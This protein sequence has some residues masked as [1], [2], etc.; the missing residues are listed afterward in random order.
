MEVE[1]RLGVLRA[2]VVRRR[3]RRRAGSSSSSSA[4]LQ[5]CGCEQ[6]A[7]DTLSL[8]LEL[9]LRQPSAPSGQD[10]APLHRLSS[11]PPQP[12]YERRLLATLDLSQWQ[13]SSGEGEGVVLDDVASAIADEE[14]LVLCCVAAACCGPSS[15]VLVYHLPPASS[16]WLSPQ[17]QTTD[18]ASPPS[19]TLLRAFRCPSPRPLHV[20]HWLPLSHLTLQ[21]TLNLAQQGFFPSLLPTA[22]P[23][24]PRPL[25]PTAPHDSSGGSAEE[26]GLVSTL[27]LYSRCTLY[28]LRTFR[29]SSSS[30]GAPPDHGPVL[31]PP[32]LPWPA[33]GAVLE[34]VEA[35]ARQG[36]LPEAI[37]LCR[38]LLQ[39]VPAD[40]ASASSSSSPWLPPAM[41]TDIAAADSQLQEL[42]GR[43]QLAKRC[44]QWMIEQGE[45]GA[46]LSFL[47]SNRDYDLHD[48]VGVLLQAGRLSEALRGSWARGGAQ[49][50]MATIDRLALQ[51]DLPLSHDDMAWLAQRQAPALLS[52]AQGALAA[53]LPPDMRLAMIF[54]DQ[55]LLLQQPSS[56]QYE[57]L[58]TSLPWLPPAC[59]ADLV[60]QLTSWLGI[61]TPCCGG[62]G[63]WPSQDW[64][65]LWTQQG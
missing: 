33:P 36:R 9:Q 56:P 38:A 26:G 17:K 59:L 10:M 15:W 32:E 29:S 24:D 60:R 6:Q 27:L 48:V 40:T 62:G 14:T 23:T 20:L 5:E 7:H 63:G 25:P 16:S 54:R 46:L 52:V 42:W 19:P 41:V 31:L 1:G 11:P 8:A 43:A 50:V 30:P 28:S 49:A 57:W 37:H 12:A 44:V 47:E 21:D 18:A 53:N 22:D 64:H 39:G 3:K 65:E 45:E 34:L 35:I 58:L 51:L 61:I 2:K 13:Q 55:Q 4:S